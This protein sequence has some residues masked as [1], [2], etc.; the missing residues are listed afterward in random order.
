MCAPPHATLLLPPPSCQVDVRD[1]ERLDY[2]WALQAADGSA[3][4]RLHYGLALARA[5]G[6]PS[7]LVEHATE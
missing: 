6:F 3:S 1:G 4:Q 5:V 2:K 7:G